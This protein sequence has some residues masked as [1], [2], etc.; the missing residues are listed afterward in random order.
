[1]HLVVVLAMEGHHALL[2]LVSLVTQMTLRVVAQTLMR[3]KGGWA[4]LAQV[5]LGV[6]MGLHVLLEVLGAG[7]DVPTLLAH[8]RLL[9]L[10]DCVVG[11]E[12]MTWWRSWSRHQ[13]VC[14]WVCS[15]YVH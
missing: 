9:I 13:S 14:G 5:G 15:S 3:A 4:V 2:A 12:G 7:E 10:V 8:V 1:M 11:L 6:V